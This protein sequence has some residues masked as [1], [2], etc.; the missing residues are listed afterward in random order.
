[1][2][3]WTNHAVPV[4]SLDSELCKYTCWCWLLAA[5]YDMQN[6]GSPLSRTSS[7]LLVVSYC[8]LP[9]A[10]WGWSVGQIMKKYPVLLVTAISL[11][12]L[13][14]CLNAPLY[15]GSKSKWV[16]GNVALSIFGATKQWI[17]YFYV[18]N[19]SSVLKIMML[20]KILWTAA[21][22]STS[23]WEQ[24]SEFRFGKFKK[25]IIAC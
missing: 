12:F 13:I 24:I 17:K 1:M 3:T 16:K 15:T 20:E 2:S 23:I 5:Q 9:S 7:D 22:S 4:I 11:L 10:L 8:Y 14:I 6:L 19:I 25:S 18:W 21:P